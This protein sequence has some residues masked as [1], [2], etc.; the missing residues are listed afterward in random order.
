MMGNPAVSLTVWDRLKLLPQALQK[1]GW[2]LILIGFPMGNT[3]VGLAFL[4]F[5]AVG[6]V[7]TRQKFSWGLPPRDAFYRWGW[8]FLGITVASA[9]QSEHL[10]VGLAVSLGFFLLFFLIVRGSCVFVNAHP[11]FH[12]NRIVYAMLCSG[13]IASIYAIYTYFG[14][15]QARASGLSI[16]INGLGTVSA[17]LTTI[18]LGYTIYSWNRNRLQSILGL[19][20]VAT[21]LGSLVLSFSRG[22]WLGFGV[23]IV[24]FFGF[25]LQDRKVKWRT[26]I[27][28]VIIIAV[29][30][31]ALFTFFPRVQDRFLSG[32]SYQSNMD[33]IVI[34]Q[35]AI[36][37]IKDNPLL[38]LGGGAFPLAYDQ[39]RVGTGTTIM[40]FAHNIILQTAAEFGLLGLAAFAMFVGVAIVRGWAVARYGGVLCQALYS[41]YLGILAHELVDDVTYGMNVGGLFWLITGLLIHLHHKM[42]TAAAET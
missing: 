4:A 34:W 23:S 28:A 25:S 2:L 42:K 41:G 3:T 13:I 7:V 39:Y 18:A 17:F 21:A 36:D 24:L 22:G 11:Y 8:V 14:L 32:F 10:A 35:A 27:T 38:G 40:A 12:P 37:M 20:L 33:R 6:R 31:A 30:V 15:G 1:L 29:M 26:V 16:G 19:V 5:G 9:L